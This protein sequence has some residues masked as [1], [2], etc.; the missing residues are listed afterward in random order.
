MIEAKAILKDDGTPLPASPSQKSNG[1]W[2]T[3]SGI[4]M[5]LLGHEKVSGAETHDGRE[6]TQNL[7]REEEVHVTRLGRKG[8]I[9]LCGILE[10][11]RVE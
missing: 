9:W 11:T 1:F 6:Y 10:Q 2:D 4:L 7:E 3:P 5:K 8:E